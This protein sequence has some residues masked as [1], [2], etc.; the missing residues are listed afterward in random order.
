[1]FLNKVFVIRWV[2]DGLIKEKGQQWIIEIVMAPT[3]LFPHFLKT[4]IYIHTYIYDE[5][6]GAPFY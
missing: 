6:H 1:M 4:H 2:N 3:A 5:N